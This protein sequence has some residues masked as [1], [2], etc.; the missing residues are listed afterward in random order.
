MHPAKVAQSREG[1]S[2]ARSLRAAGDT[3]P[4]VSEVLEVV[5]IDHTVIDVIVV[6]EWE[7]QPI[8]RPYL[9]LAID[10]FS[11]CVLGLVITTQRLIPHHCW[12]GQ[13]P[14]LWDLIR[15]F[16]PGRNTT[17]SHTAC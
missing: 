12:H 13:Q 2:V 17:M 3:P 1:S 14:T 6:D 5:Q 11:R 4:L 16:G 7:R 10:V 8:G 9:T 15:H